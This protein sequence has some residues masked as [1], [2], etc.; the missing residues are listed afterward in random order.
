L[1]IIIIA[2]AVRFAD[3]SRPIIKIIMPLFIIIILSLVGHTKFCS[4]LLFGYLIFND[5]LTFEQLLGII[6]TLIG[7]ITRDAGS[8]TQGQ[9]SSNRQIMAW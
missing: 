9:I 1:I 5:P 6:T 3:L 4:A 8:S 2:R 7:E